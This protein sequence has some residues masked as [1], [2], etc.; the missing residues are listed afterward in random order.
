MNALAQA[1]ELS[2]SPRHSVPP[3]VCGDWCA[4]AGFITGPNILLDG[5]AF[6]G[7]L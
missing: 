5:G 1:R 7:T 3:L 6:R 2:H 4:R